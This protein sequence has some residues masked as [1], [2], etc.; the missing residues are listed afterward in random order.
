MV[1]DFVA[2]FTPIRVRLLDH[3]YQLL[4]L[5]DVLHLQEFLLVLIQVLV[6]V[7]AL[8]DGS[9]VVDNQAYEQVV[10][11]DVAQK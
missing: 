5:H 3:R 10:E 2:P 1:H 6:V 8:P 9:V 4:S 11:E 7:D